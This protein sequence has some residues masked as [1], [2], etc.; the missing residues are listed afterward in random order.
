MG[1]HNTEE[2]RNACL[3]LVDE[4]NQIWKE[5]ER[6]RKADEASETGTEGDDTV[7]KP[8]FG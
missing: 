1:K 6:K 4:I 3:D 2:M 5:A 7:L 8:A